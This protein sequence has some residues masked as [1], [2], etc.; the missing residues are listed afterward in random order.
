MKN[1]KGIWIIVV[2][3]LHSIFALVNFG[4]EYQKILALGIVDSV[5]SAES[6][7]GSWF[8]LFGILI[9]ALGFMVYSFEQR[10]IS[11]PKSAALTLLILTI[12]GAAL[13]PISGF[14]LLFPPV[15]AMLYNRNRA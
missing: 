5:N 4:T 8:F 13:M 12:L 15:L 2:A 7:L 11:I 1:W 6:A 9:L 3:I 14:W 10:S